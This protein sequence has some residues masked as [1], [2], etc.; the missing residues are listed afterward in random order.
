MESVEPCMHL[1]LAEQSRAVESENAQRVGL[2]NGA[3]T[4]ARWPSRL[5][6]GLF[7]HH[8]LKVPRIIGLI[9]GF[10]SSFYTQVWYVLYTEAIS[11]LKLNDKNEPWIFIYMEFSCMQLDMLLVWDIFSTSSVRV[12]DLEL[13]LLFASIYLQAIHIMRLLASS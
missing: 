13:I 12:Y 2:P 5:L 6:S 7:T 9:S 4:L 3:V 1:F 8:G 10:T 11:T